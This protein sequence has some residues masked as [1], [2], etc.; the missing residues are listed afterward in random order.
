MEL[1]GYEEV[2]THEAQ[3]VL[4][5]RAAEQVKDEVKPNHPKARA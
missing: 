1:L 4:A 2:P 3:K 5:Q